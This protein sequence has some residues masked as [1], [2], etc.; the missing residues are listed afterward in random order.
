VLLADA[1]GRGV[2]VAHAGWRGLSGGVI[3][4]TV[5]ALRSAI[6]DADARILAFLGPAIGPAHFEVG[7]EV[8][9]AM[10]QGLPHADDAFVATGAGKFR[11]D[12]FALARQALEQV[13]VPG[14]AV[15]GGAWC[16]ASDRARFF[17]YRRDGI[18]GRHAA[19]IW[20][21]S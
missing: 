12:L 20:L 7:P 17:S 4:N 16:T 8:L 14:T 5:A 2:G 6:G 19:L 18:T 1:A 3:Q 9:A 15:S 13:Q 10:R 11:A 21:Q